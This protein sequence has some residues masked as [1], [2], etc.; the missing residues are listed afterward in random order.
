MND[1]NG[2]EIKTIKCDEDGHVALNLME[3]GDQ[4]EIR[5]SVGGVIATYIVK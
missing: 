1:R 4:I 2:N 5:N 3:K